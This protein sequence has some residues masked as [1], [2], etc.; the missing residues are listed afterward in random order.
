MSM[1][2]NLVNNAQL[3]EFNIE[4]EKRDACYFPGS[5]VSGRLVLRAKVPLEVE[6]VKVMI[7]GIAR[8][9]IKS[10]LTK[11]GIECVNT[12]TDLI[13][14]VETVAPEKAEQLPDD[15]VTSVEAKSISALYTVRA[16]ITFRT[17]ENETKKFCAVK[18]FTVVEPFDLNGLPVCYFEP[19]VHVLSKKF[20]LFSCT[21]GQIKLNF[22][23]SRTAFVC[24]ENISIEGKIEN[25]TDRRIDKVVA[26]LQQVF[27]VSGQNDESNS[28]TPETSVL[29]VSDIH[30]DNLALFVDEGQ[31]I[32]IERNFAI[33]A[34]PPRHHYVDNSSKQRT[35]GTPQFVVACK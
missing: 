8:L 7:N 24:G 1:F 13:N 31:A 9:K 33:P 6:K 11:S 30:E 23:I 10:K 2:A 21:G 18:G 5:N 35:R 12:N 32:R 28:T 26:I 22:T 19:A 29:D 17:E 3:H 20:G 4:L 15:I 27:I 16:E 25:K 34:M 14:S